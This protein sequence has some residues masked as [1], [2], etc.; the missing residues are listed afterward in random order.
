MSKERYEF[1]GK[2]GQG[3][4]GSVYRAFDTQLK[5]EVAIKRVLADGDQEGQEEATKSLLKEA[6]ALSSIEHPHIVTI[7][8]VGTDEDGPYV[9]MELINGKT[10][11]EMVENNPLTWEDLREIIL[12]SEEALAAAQNL[13]LIHRDLKPSNLM[14]SW[15]P[16]MFLCLPF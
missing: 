16:R 5:R 3:G 15:L 8:D 2:I 6:S 10:L 11:D 1:R 14:I 7:Y 4:V 9:V 13:N 12:Q